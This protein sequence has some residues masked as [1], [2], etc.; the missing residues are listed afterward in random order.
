MIA[1]CLV[2]LTLCF[3]AS[4]VV[5]Q[6]AGPPQA[7][8]FNP[9]GARKSS[10]AEFAEHERAVGV[11]Y[12][13]YI[14]KAKSSTQIRIATWNAHMLLDLEEKYEQVQ[15]VL[16]DLMKI[17]ADVLLLQE[18]PKEREGSFSEFD[19]GLEK[20]GYLHREVRYSQEE[21]AML[22]IMIA[23]RYPISEVEHYELGFKRIFVDAKIFGPDGRSFH[24]LG[25]H[26]EVTQA[27]IRRDQLA[28]IIEH[29]K[30]NGMYA[31]RFILS[32]DFNSQWKSTEMD[33]IRESAKNA[34]EAF[35]A[36]GWDRPEYTC[37]SGAAID[38]LFVGAELVERLAGAYVYHSSTSDHLPV[39]VDILR[40]A[41][42]QDAITVESN[43]S[44][45]QWLLV[46]VIILALVYGLAF[47]FLP[48][49]AWNNAYR[50]MRNY[51][52]F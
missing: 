31:G 32:G 1:R 41:L 22:G 43:S 46:V 24:V 30:Q 20:L 49:S 50:S 13:E 12:N 44:D 19:A 27:S 14:P 17:E 8:S 18:V 47:K 48:R 4:S 36:L 34:R 40:E 35:G 16:R 5:S 15:A 29:L 33:P 37:W 11:K 21:G 9:E 28:Y 2:C 39:L 51:D 10:R 45:L 42:K 7:P 25:T 26:L 6:K 3:Q 52:S 38:F 23:S